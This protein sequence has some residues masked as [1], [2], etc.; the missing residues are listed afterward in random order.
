[1]SSSNHTA[2]LSRYRPVILTLTGTLV[3]Y[4]VYS[5]YTTWINGRKGP[6]LRRRNAIRRLRPSSSLG[7]SQRSHVEASGETPVQHGSIGNYLNLEINQPS[8]ES[9][10]SEAGPLSD[11]GSLG[12]LVIRTDSGEDILVTLELHTLPTVQELHNYFRLSA[13]D[14]ENAREYVEEFFVSRYLE[15]LF[16]QY[17]TATLSQQEGQLLIEW[18]ES[19]GLGHDIVCRAFHNFVLSRE[20]A[21]HSALQTITER[22]ADDTTTSGIRSPVVNDPTDRNFATSQSRTQASQM[23]SGE[24]EGRGSH[25]KSMLYYIAEEQA[26]QDGYIH[27]GVTCDSCD[28]K[29]I[30]GIR[31]RCANCLD[32]DLCSDCEAVSDHP[33]THIF[34]KV[35]IPAHF[36]GNPKQAQPVLYPGKP[37]LMPDRLP[38]RMKKRM[39]DETRFESAEVEALWDQFRCLANRSWGG[40]PNQLG[41]AIDRRAFDQSFVPHSCFYPSI[42]N[43]IYDRMFA[44]YDTNGD[45]LIG[46]EEFIKGLSNLRTQDRET[47]LRQIFNGYDV[48]CDGLVARKDFLRMFRA[49][50]AIQKDVARDLIIVQQ[51]QLDLNGTHSII[52]SGQPLSAAFNDLIPATERRVPSGKPPD[53][54]G[55]PQANDKDI[56]VESAEE[57]GDRRDVLG[58]VILR[59]VNAIQDD[60]ENASSSSD[61]TSEEHSEDHFGALE[62]T[63]SQAMTGA[64]ESE[65]N[66]NGSSEPPVPQH[67]VADA[68]TASAVEANTLHPREDGYTVP[69]LPPAPNYSQTSNSEST[70]TDSMPQRDSAA[71]RERWRRR[72]FYVDEEEGF[73]APDEITNHSD[74][75]S[76]MQGTEMNKETNGKPHDVTCT[77]DT[78]KQQHEECSEPSSYKKK[79]KLSNATAESNHEDKVDEI[80]RTTMIDPV[81]DGSNAPSGR[82]SERFQRSRSSSKVRFEDDPEMDT[83]SNA[84]T[85]SRPIGE[86]W[87]GYEIPK[88]ELDIAGEVLYQVTQQALNELLDPLFKDKEDLA[89]QVWESYELRSKLSQHINE[90]CKRNNIDD[91]M[92]VATI[93]S[94][95]FNKTGTENGTLEKAIPSENIP[96]TKIAEPI[97]QFANETEPDVRS[98]IEAT[99][100]PND[101]SKE[102]CFHTK[103]ENKPSSVLDPAVLNVPLDQLAKSC[104]YT[105][106][107]DGFIHVP[108]DNPYS[109]IPA[110]EKIVPDLGR[111]S[112]VPDKHQHV[113]SA[114]YLHTDEPSPDPTLPQN[115]PHN[116]ETGTNVYNSETSSRSNTKTAADSHVIDLRPQKALTSADSDN[117]SGASSNIAM[118]PQALAIQQVLFE[119]PKSNQKLPYKDE[120][121]QP[122][123]E[124]IA[125]LAL[126][127]AMNREMKERNGAGRICFNEFASILQSERGRD[128][129]FVEGWLETAS[130]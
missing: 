10:I 22:H 118:T 40:D 82:S 61:S 112:R 102:V 23:D 68:T 43:L 42:P 106:Y 11:V 39:I 36:L 113:T 109:E 93:T 119:G 84:S 17:P 9:R 53:R 38:T 95:V 25:L 123:E 5:I 87:G 120:V 33:I 108:M 1:M 41:A 128:L 88:A 78:K 80:K 3:A 52:P 56:I 99:E 90:F 21:G 75:N 59:T 32:Y 77:T 69:S 101:K 58:D 6:N 86:R 115:R 28:A 110:Y 20:A 100:A 98:S 94:K 49:Y 24:E 29:P 73:Q 130:C 126:I 124:L 15:R 60:S 104:G 37:E 26:R 83:R 45:S 125:R 111:Q 72:S 103:S 46:Y 97:P 96:S 117:R 121:R 19:R 54:F 79:R 70:R 64:L 127:N 57:E 51:D 92:D 65:Q 2:S 105:L 13:V 71:I 30:R 66:I 16:Q 62:N 14:A 107:E 27:R 7:R 55:D 74:S 48:D 116:V 122:S 67:E 4:G 129:A 63:L 18:F 85:S 76:R 35:K 44:F 34:Y 50:Y 8:G 89:M 114:E 31:W 81:A 12:I 91:S 47:K